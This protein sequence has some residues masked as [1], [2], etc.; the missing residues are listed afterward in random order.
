MNKIYNIPS[1]YIAQYGVRMDSHQT[2]I[3]EYSD[4]DTNQWPIQLG[5]KLVYF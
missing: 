4:T 3:I 5:N 1:H 2:Y